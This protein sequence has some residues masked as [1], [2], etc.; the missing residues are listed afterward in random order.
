MVLNIHEISFLEKLMNVIFLHQ[1]FPESGV[2]QCV[3]H[4]IK[5]LV[6]QKMSGQFAF[7]LCILLFFLTPLFMSLLIHHLVVLKT[8]R[9]V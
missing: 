6:I 9:C 5:P 2:I 4:I 3:L 8:F 7:L 1:L